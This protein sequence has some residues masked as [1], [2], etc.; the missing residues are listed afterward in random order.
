MS[1]VEILVINA[2]VLLAGIAIGAAWS[3]AVYQKR[4]QYFE[5]L[6]SELSA[7]VP[8]EDF[9]R[10]LVLPTARER[11]YPERREVRGAHEEIPEVPVTQ[12]R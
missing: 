4:V 2:F 5:E 7:M 9:A 8:R 10:S 1:N 11:M 3:G 12:A 6:A